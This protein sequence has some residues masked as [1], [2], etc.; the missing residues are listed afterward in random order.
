M[1]VLVPHLGTKQIDL[2]EHPVHTFL[3]IFFELLCHEKHYFREATCDLD[4]SHPSQLLQGQNYHLLFNSS[5]PEML[6]PT[7][8][9]SQQLGSEE[10]TKAS[11]SLGKK[12]PLLGDPNLKRRPLSCLC[13]KTMNQ[14][15]AQ[16]QG[17][18]HGRG[19]NLQVFL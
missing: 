13:R 17:T 7:Q 16:P 11:C 19:F 18:K 2:S 14:I 1:L 10:L 4:P 12:Q 8:I 9:I 5:V 6:G 15:R 3:A